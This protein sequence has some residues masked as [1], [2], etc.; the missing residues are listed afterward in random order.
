MPKAKKIKKEEKEIEKGIG[1]KPEA[2]VKEQESV[3]DAEPKVKYELPQVEEKPGQ[4]VKES[5]EV[6]PASSIE[7]SPPSSPL[8][9]SSP[10]SQEPQEETV[11]ESEPTTQ[12][13]G[14]S[15]DVLSDE[16]EAPD[17]ITPQEESPGGNRFILIGLVIIVVCTLI[18]GGIYVYQK[19]MKEASKPPEA[20]ETTPPPTSPAEKESEASPTPSLAAELKREDLKIQVLNGTGVPGVAA[21]A[22][23]Y[24][25]GLGYQGIG[26][27]NADN[28]D[29]E[30]TEISIKADKEEYLDLL[31]ADLES[32]Y[33]VSTQTAALDEASDFDA[34]VTIGKK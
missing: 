4:P 20:S 16:S 15:E 11:T 5:E 1:K 31:L 12:A 18:A 10:P 26:A 19:A 21:K 2:P 14:L 29:Y 25:E 13:V 28:Y 22:Q 27:G 23:A 9:V 33:T 24:L 6:S 17:S 30:E 32:E 8:D 7:E 34:V 3:K